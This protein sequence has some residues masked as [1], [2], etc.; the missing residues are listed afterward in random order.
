MAIGRWDCGE[1]LCGS[2]FKLQGLWG[3]LP[4]GDFFSPWQGEGG[5]G[6]HMHVAT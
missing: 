3:L 2:K 4:L 6:M 5:E 1:F